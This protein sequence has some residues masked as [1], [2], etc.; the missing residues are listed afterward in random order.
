MPLTY[1]AKSKIGAIHQ[2]ELYQAMN[3]TARP[4]NVE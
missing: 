3:T 4:E 2:I 1:P